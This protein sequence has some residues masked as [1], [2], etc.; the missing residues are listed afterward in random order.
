MKSKL[1][2]LKIKRNQTVRFALLDMTLTR[3]RFGVL[4][5]WKQ[6]MYQRGARAVLLQQRIVKCCAK[7]TIGQKVIGN[8]TKSG[9]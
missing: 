2:K 8:Q 1:A 7:P 9:K 6:I 3:K 5:K 4:A